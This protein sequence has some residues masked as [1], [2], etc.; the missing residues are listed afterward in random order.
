MSPDAQSILQQALSLPAE[1]QAEIAD[2]LNV[3][4]AKSGRLPFDPSWLEETERR[5]ARY[6]AGL[7]QPVPWE[8]VR[9]EVQRRIGQ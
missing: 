9:A 8:E 6:D 4:A 5:L 2:A 3:A 1:D 7:S